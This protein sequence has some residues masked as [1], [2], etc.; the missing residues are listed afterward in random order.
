MELDEKDIQILRELQEN[1]RTPFAKI[2]LKIELTEGA[3]RARVRRL[4]REK[5]IES[6]TIALNQELTG[7]RILA[8]IGVDANPSDLKVIATELAKFE[9]VY[10]VALATGTHDVLVDVVTKD[11]ESLKKFLLDKLGRTSG[12]RGSDTSLVID[13]YKWKGAYQYKI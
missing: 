11:M 8:R 9:E 1:S 6:F 12:I 2:G 7:A 4:V 5:V 13:V 10:F 3:V